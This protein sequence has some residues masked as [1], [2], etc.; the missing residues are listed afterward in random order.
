MSADAKGRHFARVYFTRSAARREV[1]ESLAD[2]DSLLETAPDIPTPD[3]FQY[4][5]AVV[6]SDP[7]TQRTLQQLERH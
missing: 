5:G 1:A 7:T 4:D 6:L 3:A 2:S